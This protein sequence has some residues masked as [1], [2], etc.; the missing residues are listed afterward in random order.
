MNGPRRTSSTPSDGKY[1]S[2]ESGVL[3]FYQRWISPARGATHCPMHPS[4]SQY[5]KQAFDQLPWY[6]AYVR[7][8]ERLLRCGNDLD[9]Y[10][11]ILVDGEIRWLDPIPPHDVTTDAIQ[12]P[13][14]KSCLGLPLPRSTGD[15]PESR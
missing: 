15:E 14:E 11:V 5:A 9:D 12:T 2:G 10:P 8:L 3:D 4:C 13:A 1:G 6:E 7:T